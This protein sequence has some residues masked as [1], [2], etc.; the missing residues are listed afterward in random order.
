MEEIDATVVSETLR[1]ERHG[2]RPWSPRHRN[3]PYLKGSVHCNRSHSCPRRRRGS[4]TSVASAI[5]RRIQVER[6]ANGTRFRV[7]HWMMPSAPARQPQEPA[8]LAGVER[9]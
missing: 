8:F 5:S 1:T 9:L 7:T 6:E 3:E 2:E 4:Q